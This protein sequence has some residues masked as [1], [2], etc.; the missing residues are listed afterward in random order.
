MVN[1][2]M[3][4]D[5]KRLAPLYRLTVGEPG[6]SH[7]LEIASRYGLPDHVVRFARSMIGSMEA[8]FHAL[9]RDLKDKGERLDQ[10]LAE[11]ASREERLLRSERDLAGRAAQAARDSSGV[12]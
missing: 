11:L 8:D 4:F 2:A 3:A 7:A 5:R 12:S 1:A 10:T 6:E 9:L